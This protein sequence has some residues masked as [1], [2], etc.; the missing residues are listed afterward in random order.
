[1]STTPPA[2]SPPTCVPS[3]GRPLAGGPLAPLS[4]SARYL[5]FWGG[6]RAPRPESA[7]GSPPS[8]VPS[9]PLQP[10][11]T[12]PS[13][14]GI[15]VAG[16]VVGGGGGRGRRLCDKVGR[17]CAAA[18]AGVVFVATCAA[19]WTAAS[20]CTG[21]D[22]AVA[23]DLAVAAADVRPR[24]SEVALAAGDR[25]MLKEA[26]GGGM[27]AAAWLAAFPRTLV[28]SLLPHDLYVCTV[29]LLRRLLAF[30]R[31]HRRS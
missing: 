8:A 12:L 26:G 18:E 27:T 1:M 13:T 6:N 11:L 28:E 23:G 7:R 17:L 30:G 3:A 2:P 29:V 20:A 4:S 22:R 24:A 19:G 25:G 14:P 16:G 5:P 10:Q 21:R 31:E 9:P 15:A